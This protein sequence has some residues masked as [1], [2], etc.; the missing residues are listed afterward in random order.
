MKLRFLGTRGLLEVASHRHPR[1]S[2]LLI[3]NGQ[4]RLLV[5]CGVDWREDF[6]SLMPQAIVLTHAHPDHA[7][8]LSGGAPCPVYATAETWE[9]L[10]DYPVASRELLHPGRPIL[11]QGVW[12]A[13]RPVR[14]SPRIS[15][16]GLRI[17]GG[18][19]DFF[20]APDLIGIPDPRR[21][22]QGVSLY[23]GDGS[24]F[25]GALTREENGQIYGHAPIPDQ[26]RWCAEYGVG[27]A[28]FT[29]CGEEIVAGD[30]AMKIGELE[31]WGT[32]LG[33][34]ARLA[35]DGLEVEW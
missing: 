3:Q 28:I 17:R 14:H 16:I 5:D 12:L 24:S 32:K 31:V 33:V 30:E 4:H 1:H 20:Y 10:A 34:R 27:E 22:L 25:T 35:H 29:H 11:I 2:S 23:I 21:A 19:G 8:G 9:A 13:P 7:G 26:L 18:K 6:R 15:T